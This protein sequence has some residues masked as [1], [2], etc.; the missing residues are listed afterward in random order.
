VL[1][2]C[3][4]LGSSVADVLFAF[5]DLGEPVLRRLDRGV[6]GVVGQVEEEGLV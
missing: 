6:R 1:D 5:L 4:E 3:D 2:E